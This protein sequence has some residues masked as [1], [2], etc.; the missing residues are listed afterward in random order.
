MKIKEVKDRLKA[1]GVKI[2]EGASDEQV[3]AL[4][5]EHW[6]QGCGLVQLAA[7]AAKQNA[8]PGSGLLPAGMSEEEV[9]V[10]TLAGLERHQAII[11]ILAQYV[12][13]LGPPAAVH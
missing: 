8:H 5:R 9:R 12:E 11:V 4:A 3:K 7:V 10:K 1:D 13:D 2:P 6:S